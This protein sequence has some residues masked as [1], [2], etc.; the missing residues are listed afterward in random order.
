[1]IFSFGA[2]EKVKIYEAMNEHAATVERP[3]RG[4]RVNVPT[5]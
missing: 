2:F 5:S 3:P 4:E 1:V